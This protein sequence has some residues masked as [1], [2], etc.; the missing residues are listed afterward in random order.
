MC[1]PQQCIDRNKQ[2]VQPG[3]IVKIHKLN[4]FA[5]IKLQENWNVCLDFASER[6]ICFV[7]FCAFVIPGVSECTSHTHLIQCF[8]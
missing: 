6:I 1:N 3:I 2:L 5:G 4:N 8:G 7:L